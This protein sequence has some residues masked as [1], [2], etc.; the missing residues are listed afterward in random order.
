MN[1]RYLLAAVALTV[2]AAVTTSAQH[3]PAQHDAAPPDAVVPD[4]AQDVAE[5]VADVREGVAEISDDPWQATDDEFREAVAAAARQAAAAA[6]SAKDQAQRAAAEGAKQAGAAFEQ[7]EAL[8]REAA[9]MA[10]SARAAADEAR[11]QAA[12]AAA[13]AEH[14]ARRLAR[15]AA[16]RLGKATEGRRQGW[17][18]QS[19]PGAPGSYSAAPASQGGYS[20]RDWGQAPAG[21]FDQQFSAP[22]WAFDGENH[23]WTPAPTE[24]AANGPRVAAGER[25]PPRGTQPLFEPFAE[26]QNVNPVPGAATGQQPNVGWGAPANRGA[27]HPEGWRPNG[28]PAMNPWEGAP[29]APE[30][31]LRDT[32]FELERLAHGLERD[33][34]YE[35]ADTL[36]RASQA[37]RQQARERAKQPQT[38]TGSALQSSVPNAE[39]PEPRAEPTEAPPHNA[40]VAARPPVDRE[41]LQRRLLD[42]RKRIDQKLERL[43]RAAVSG[44]PTEPL[45][46]LE[47]APQP[48]PAAR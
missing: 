46:A 42:E 13:R 48:N 38:A 43:R 22:V 47:A 10:A 21:A 35:G 40:P 30:T 37:L 5:A 20:W 44:G 41:R 9:E 33:S 39:W 34:L 1:A 26:A 31:R 28:L 2:A 24:A 32:A 16:Q 36:R 7:A 18:I 25:Q 15:E 14:E 12:A 4:A 3:D 45:R 6:E 8:R 11:R 29:P 23:A 27:S 17:S 19:A